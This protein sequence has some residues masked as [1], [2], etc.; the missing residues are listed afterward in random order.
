M[1]RNIFI[2]CGTNLGQGLKKIVLLENITHEW[3]VYSFEANPNT[4]LL[5]DKIAHYRYYNVAVSDTYHFSSFNCERWDNNGFIGGASTLLDLDNWHTER[6]Y[7][8]KPSNIQTFVPVIDLTDFIFRLRPEKKSIVLKLDV[9]GSEYKILNKF[10][11]LNVFMFIRKI[12]I[13]FHD[14]F[15][16]TPE[17]KPSHYW[18]NFFQKNDIDFVLWD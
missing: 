6:V 9:E 8:F 3:D 13:E 10:E 12:Y 17:N 1:K 7:G 14:H 5:T 15:L 11:T 16:S 18:I 4:F 2:D